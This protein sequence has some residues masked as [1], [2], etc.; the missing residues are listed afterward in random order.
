[1]ASGAEKVPLALAKRHRFVLVSDLDW[2]MVKE[3]RD[4]GNNTVV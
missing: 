2:T 1:M 4:K 3:E